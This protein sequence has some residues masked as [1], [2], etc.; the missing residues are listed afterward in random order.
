MVATGGRCYSNGI[1]DLT[2]GLADHAM[3][4]PAFNL[5]PRV[6]FEQGTKETRIPIRGRQRHPAYIPATVWGSPG[7]T[8]RTSRATISRT[9]D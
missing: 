8:F 2:L 4:H 5:V 7:T 1:P 9:C 6:S 3:H